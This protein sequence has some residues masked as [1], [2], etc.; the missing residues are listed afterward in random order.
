MSTKIYNGYKVQLFP[1]WVQLQHLNNE[2]T[3]ECAKAIVDLIM[4]RIKE[5]NSKPPENLTPWLWRLVHSTRQ[6][7]RENAKSSVRINF[8]LEFNVV[9]L[10]HNLAMVFCEHEPYKEAFM[11]VTGAEEYFYWSNSDPPED[12][13][14]GLWRARG[15]LWDQALGGDGVP[16][17]HG[18]VFNP[19]LLNNVVGMEKDMVQ[20]LKERFKNEYQA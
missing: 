12:I 14:D 17:N 4:K 15:A 18:L 13:S 10:K 5:M 16:S 7:L 1:D 9:F 2:L 11:D 3:K 20:E 6:D 19:T 8:D